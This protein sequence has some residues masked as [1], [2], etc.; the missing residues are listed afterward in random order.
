MS[1]IKITI[2]TAT[3]ADYGKLKSIIIKLQKDNSFDTEIFV[4]GMHNLNL[5]GKTIGEI[6]KDKIKKLYI[7]NNQRKNSSMNDILIN[8]IKGF[9][10]YIE[11]KKP[12]FI[13]IHGDRIEPLACSLSAIL[14]NIKIVHVEGGEVS[15][16]VDEMLRHSISK[17]SHHHLVSNLSAKKRLIQMGEKKNS[18]SIVGSP[19]VDLVLS[20]NLPS[21]QFVLRRYGVKF[22]NYAISILHPV[23]TNI[24]NVERET[25]IY[26]ESL[27]ESKKNFI[28]ILPNNDLGS[29]FIIDKIKLLKKRKNIK[30]IPSLRFEYFLTLLKNS[31]LMIGNSSSGIMEAPYYG[32]P[33]INI[34]NRQKN[35]LN[36]ESIKNIEFKK[37][38]II[39]FINRFYGKK[40][41]RKKYFG[42]GNTDNKVI[43]VLKSK[44]FLNSNLQ[45]N[46]IDILN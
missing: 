35:R 43:K 34:G 30:I 37:K 36:A 46:F 25:D 7:F 18:I 11:K 44:S 26:F 38:K 28:I 31:S 45:K 8:T 19:D 33:T 10:N 27:I 41:H 24:N 2:V 16:T 21:K 17:L 40:F 13:L 4:T 20:K 6:K 29:N 1:K 3:R 23:T 42:S 39:S 5:Y 14:K 9:T 15:G 12:D 32:I 22:S